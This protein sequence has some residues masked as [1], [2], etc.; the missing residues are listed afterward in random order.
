MSERVIAYFEKLEG[1]SNEDLDHSAQ[2]LA[3]HEK[4][5]SARLIAHIAEIGERK[6]QVKLGYQ[7]L[8]EYCVKRL[9][10]SEGAV[11]RRTQVAGKSRRFPQILEALF[12][13]RLHLTGASLIAPHLTEDNAE[14]LISKAQGKTRREI[15]KLLITLA[16]KKEF[17][18]SIRKQPRPDPKGNA[19]KVVGEDSEVPTLGEATGEVKPPV[20]S[21]DQQSRDLIEPATE[22][23]YNFRFSAGKEFT[24]KFKRLGEVIGVKNPQNHLE[25]ILGKALDI[26]LEKK[27][28]RQKLKRRRER[29]AKKRNSCRREDVPKQTA[30]TSGSGSGSPAVSRHVSSEIRERVLE[31]AGYQ[32]QYCGPEGTRCTSKT[33]LQIE[34]TKPFAVYQT[35]DEAY[36]RAFCPAHNLFA[37]KAF[38]GT[39]FIRQKID[40]AQHKKQNG[41]SWRP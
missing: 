21:A 25:E 40:G 17:A 14:N 27:D 23:R 1:L 37:A 12:S 13:G 39:E 5:N 31:R 4:Q 32:C 29:E 9:N 16:P 7:N 38:F 8:F 33:G 36:L 15:V 6:Y 34:H 26:A 22:E 18:P 35:H 3:L 19:P 20:P 2:E 10:L 24:E 11:F 28:P 30:E 41:V